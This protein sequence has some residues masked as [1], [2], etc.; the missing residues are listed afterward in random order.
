[1]KHIGSRRVAVALAA[2]S[3]SVAPDE[4]L[5]TEGYYQAG[6]GAVQKSL[7]GAGAANPEDATTLSINPA[8]LAFVGRQLNAAMTTFLPSRSYTATGT[9][10]IAPGS[11]TSDQSPTATRSTRTRPSV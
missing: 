7:A 6:N 10:I 11:V 8:G 4:A 2:A 1:M 5:A 3:A 9:T